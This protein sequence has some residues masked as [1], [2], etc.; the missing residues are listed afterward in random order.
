MPINFM[1]TY[2]VTVLG[3][4][5]FSCRVDPFAPACL[6]I[7]RVAALINMLVVLA[8]GAV[9]VLNGHYVVA[10]LLVLVG[11]PVSIG[12]FVAFGLIIDYAH[13]Q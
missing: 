1:F 13:T 12:H 10:P 11:V 9:L 5:S 4:S 7:T 8:V 3:L 6:H 2:S